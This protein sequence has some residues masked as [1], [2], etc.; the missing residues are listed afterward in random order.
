MGLFIAVGVFHPGGPAKPGGAADQ[1]LVQLFP[2]A[3]GPHE[4]LVVKTCRQQRRQ[5]LVDAQRVKPQR[6]PAVLAIGDQAVVKLGGGGAR[7]GLAPGTGA[8]FHQ[9]IGFLDPRRDDAARQMVFE[10]ATDEL[11]IVGDES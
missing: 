1:R 5:Q 10:R 6:R 9:R 3:F 2:E 11:D 7:I 4:G 8:Q